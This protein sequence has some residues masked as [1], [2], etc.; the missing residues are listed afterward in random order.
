MRPVLDTNV[1]IS[2]F[3][4]GGSP[5]RLLKLGPNAG[6]RFYS[7]RRL[8]TELQETILR[9]KFRN[10]ILASGLTAMDLL[11]RYAERVILVEP[12]PTPGLAPGPDDDV[13]IG[14]AIA[15]SAE[16][17]VTGARTLLS[18]ARFKGGRIVFVQDA[19]GLL[20]LN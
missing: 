5:S 19:L 7:S 4:W 16:V 15:A 17:I 20:D 12:L 13:G 6:L 14:T 10:R 8:L 9:P 2:A 11:N 1:A 18:V 3:L